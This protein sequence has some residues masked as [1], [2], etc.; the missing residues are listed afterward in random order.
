M[1][2]L[3]CTL[4]IVFLCAS[5]GGSGTKEDNSSNTTAPT[6]KEVKKTDK[7]KMIYDTD[8]GIDDAMA[9][10]YALGSPDI[11]LIGITTTFGNVSTETSMRNTLDILKL[12]NREDVPVY[13]GALHSYSTTATFEA[14]AGIKRIHG[15]NGIGNVNLEK[16]DKTAANGSA[17]DFIIESAKKY[18]KDLTIVAVGPVTN[19]EDAIK[20]EP[21]LKDMVGG[22]VIMG[23][24]LTVPGNVSQ[25][26]EANI[27]ADAV[28]ANEFFT[29]GTPFTMVG[30]DVTNR[31]RLTKEDTKK[32]R[33]IGTKSATTF[34]DIVDYYISISSSG[35]CALHDPLA[36]GVAVNPDLVQTLKMYMVVGTE[37]ENWGRTVGDKTKLLEP[38]PNV[39]VCVNVDYKKFA[40]DF[41]QV[42]SDLFKKN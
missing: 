25:L 12:L 42:L 8:L 17:V 9:L 41:N 24:A 38:N 31:V 7:I 2:N 16:S 33:E 13:Y 15:E 23:G 20:K 18:G 36:V 21:K 19:I 26:A 6:A 29:S 28:A 4:A 35:S 32:W 40:G 22:I 37:K 1:K 3:I 5:C 11:D 10:A 30:L 27:N 14:G 39:T 34:A